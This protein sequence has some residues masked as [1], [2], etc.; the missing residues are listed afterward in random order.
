[1]LAAT[2]VAR[3]VSAALVASAAL[4]NPGFNGAVLGLCAWIFGYAAEVG[5]LWLRLRAGVTMAPPPQSSN[6]S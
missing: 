5:G 6:R 3:I 1:M 2:G 4:L